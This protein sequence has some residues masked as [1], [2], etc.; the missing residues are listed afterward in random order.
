MNKIILTV[1]MAFVFVLCSNLDKKNPKP[2]NIYIKDTKYNHTWVKTYIANARYGYRDS[3]DVYHAG[4]WFSKAYDW[5]DF[6]KKYPFFAFTNKS[7]FFI[8]FER[9]SKIFSK[10]L[11]SD[12]QGFSFKTS[13]IKLYTSGINKNLITILN[14]EYYGLTWARLSLEVWY[15]KEGDISFKWNFEIQGFNVKSTVKV[16]LPQ[17]TY[18]Y[19]L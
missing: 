2:R 5:N 7:V 6:V 9:D 12:S 3:S 10:S 18:R 11:T 4:R 8:N 15:T 17:I 16:H 19:Y 13:D 14:F 1:S